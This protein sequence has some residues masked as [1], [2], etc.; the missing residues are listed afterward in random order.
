MLFTALVSTTLPN[1]W[2]YFTPDFF[3]TYAATVPYWME[4]ECSWPYPNPGTTCP[5]VGT[6]GFLRSR[7][8][9]I[10]DNVVM[11]FWVDIIVY[12]G[13][14]LIIPLV[15]FGLRLTASG[16]AILAKRVRCVYLGVHKTWH[17]PF[18]HLGTISFGGIIVWCFLFHAF[19]W[20][21]RYWFIEHNWVQNWPDTDGYVTMAER[22]ARTSGQVAIFFEALLLL[23]ASRNSV[24][25]VFFGVGWEVMLKFHRV[26][27][28][29]MLASSAVHLIAWIVVYKEQKDVWPG[30]WPHDLYQIPN[31][32]GPQVDNFTVI[33]ITWVTYIMFIVM[34]VF[35]FHRIRRLYFEWFYYSH[36][37]FVVIVVTSMWHAA[38]GF[39]YL[40]PPIFLWI[41]DRF[42]RWYKG[43]SPATITQVRISEDIVELSMSTPRPFKYMAGQYLFINVPGISL[44]Q[45]HPFTISSS[46]LDCL[47]TLH[48]KSMGRGTWTQK[49]LQRAIEGKLEGTAVALD[50]PVGHSVPFTDYDKVVLVCGGI[51]VT[52]VH[53]IFKELY[54]CGNATGSLFKPALVKAVWSARSQGVFRLFTSGFSP[55]T[56]DTQDGKFSVHLYGPP[57]SATTTQAVEKAKQKFKLSTLEEADRLLPAPTAGRPN[58]AGLLAEE[59]VLGS[60]R[61]LVFVCGPATMVQSCEEAA[62][63]YG[64]EFHAETFEL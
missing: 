13:H 28:Y 3:A 52:P 16:R 1:S 25:P 22:V 27:G 59:S 37:F 61:G 60:A 19:V 33:A 7:A 44:L 29:G 43:C 11:K 8:H 26:L 46:P 58:V 53:S 10:S 9:K 2:E 34:G 31:K 17:I 5:E 62:L 35:T 24:L 48:I 23:P 42:I 30:S 40:T 47:V 55:A 64:W 14:L 57:P 32:R 36:F 38:Q 51:G 21:T 4:N 12:Y 18:P 41:V 45:W 54:Q 6:W 15:G 63:A 56:F 49:L 50:G 39:S 20:W